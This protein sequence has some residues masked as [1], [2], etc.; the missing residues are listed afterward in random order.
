MVRVFTLLIAV[1]F[2][3]LLAAVPAGAD[4]TVK[5]GHSSFDPAKVTIKKGESVTFHNV[6]EMPG[7]HTVVADDG[8]WKSPPLKLNEE[9]TKRFEQSGTVKIHV[10]QH[11]KTTGE[12]VVE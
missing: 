6:Q 3:V 11:P 2:A 7:G 10:E 5:V 8:S 12:I 4:A 9:F 1:A